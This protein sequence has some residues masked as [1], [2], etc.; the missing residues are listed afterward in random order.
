M[1]FSLVYKGL[2][3]FDLKENNRKQMYDQ[4]KKEDTTF[5]EKN[6]CF[7]KFKKKINLKINCKKLLASYI[8][9]YALLVCLFETDKR[10]NS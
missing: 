8:S 3:F 5:R 6:Y 2:E 9:I 4:V 10:Q 7:F 1:H